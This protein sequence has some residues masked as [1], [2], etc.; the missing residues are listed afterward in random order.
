M[1][2]AEVNI[3][4][5]RSRKRTRGPERG[6]EVNIQ[7]RR[8]NLMTRGQYRGV[9]GRK[10]LSQFPSNIPCNEWKCSLCLWLNR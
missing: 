3:E 7:D 9:S 10:Y 5:R 6:R 1:T 4:D 2:G 8:S